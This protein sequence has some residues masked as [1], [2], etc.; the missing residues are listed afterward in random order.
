MVSLPSLWM[1]ILLSTVLV[2]LASFVTHMVLKYHWSDFRR[3]P[4]EDDVM[5]TLRRFNIPPGDYVVPHPK[6]AAAL[7]SKEF[8]EK[9]ARGPRFVATIV[10]AG[11]TGMGAQLAQWFVFCTVVSVFAGYLTSRS[12]PAGAEYLHVSQVASTTAFIG[13]T[14]AR[15][16]DVIWYRRSVT[17]ALKYTF[18]GLLFGFITGGTFGGLWPQ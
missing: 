17:T 4:L 16:A 14:L 13:Y 10:P 18:D 6:D 11:Q 1:P 2:F 9:V 5:E 15:W 8:Q 12:V 7:R 3:M